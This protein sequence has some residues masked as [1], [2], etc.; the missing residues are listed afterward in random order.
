MLPFFCT[1]SFGRISHLTSG[2]RRMP[3]PCPQGR[4]TGFTLIELLVV[5]AIIAVLI[6]LL[7]PAVQKV[8]EAGNR[9]QCATNLKQLGLARHHFHDAYSHFPLSRRG[10]LRH[11]GRVSAALHRAGQ[12]VQALERGDAPLLRHP[13]GGPA[14]HQDPV[15]P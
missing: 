10:Q 9:I 6:A 4:R 15:L 12:P 13:C 11:L 2:V 14:A 8:R 1:V 3:T 7:V 5:I